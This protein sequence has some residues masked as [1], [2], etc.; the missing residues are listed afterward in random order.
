VVMQSPYAMSSPSSAGAIISSKMRE[1]GSLFANVYIL[2]E[3]RFPNL[4]E[5]CRGNP[6]CWDSEE[7]VLVTDCKEI[8]RERSLQEWGF[9]KPVGYGE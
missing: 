4:L 6:S 8:R 3:S 1:L 2:I 9:V 7:N 5:V